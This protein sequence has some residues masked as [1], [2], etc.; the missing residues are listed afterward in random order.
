MES[1]RNKQAIIDFLV[2][3]NTAEVVA[4]N[5]SE[6]WFSSTSQAALLLLDEEVLTDQTLYPPQEIMDMNE[7]YQ[8]MSEANVSYRNRIVNLFCR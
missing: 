7:L 1:S 3:I 8:S 6:V 4:K 5:S 2:F